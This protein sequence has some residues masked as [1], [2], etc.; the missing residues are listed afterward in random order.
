MGQAF[1]L[2][3]LRH[4]EKRPHDILL[5]LDFP[6]LSAQLGA[7]RLEIGVRLFTDTDSSPVPAFHRFIQ[8]INL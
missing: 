2:L 4:F 6:S 3:F 7:V 5:G 8:F 1:W